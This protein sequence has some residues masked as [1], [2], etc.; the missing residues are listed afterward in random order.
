MSISNSMKGVICCGGT[1][2]RLYPLTKIT[3]KH[4]INIYNRQMVYYP[5]KTLVESGIEEIM[6]VSGKGHCGQFLE[7]LEDGRDEFGVNL[8]Y[9]VQQEPEGI[10][11]A[12]GLCRRFIGDNRV[13]CILGDNIYE[14]KFDFSD[15][16][17]NGELARIYL[18]YVPDAYR[19]GVAEFKEV[20]VGDAPERFQYKIVGIEEK[21]KITSSEYA[22]TGLY[23]YEK[24]VFNIINGLRPSDRGELEI[25]D[26][27]NW[28][29]KK[30]KMDYRIIE[31]FWSDA[32][33]F[34]SL[35]RANVFARTK[36]LN[37][38]KRKEMDR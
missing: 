18:K 23:L 29:I 9:R 28:Y 13:A 37:G 19:F 20:K 14:D 11:Q 38:K 31:G 15:F 2:L 22:V 25:S 24:S 27:N 36:E 4:L 6:I 17:E 8:S 32:G 1:G 35:Y 5:L 3:N 34:D 21:P 33:T 10:A 7:L 12:L 26:V 16:E 30:E